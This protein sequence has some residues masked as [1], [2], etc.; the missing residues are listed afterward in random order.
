[1]RWVFVLL[2][3]IGVTASALAL[4]EHYRTD[5][6]PCSINE[7][8]DCGIVNHSPYAMLGKIPVAVIG[9]IGYFLLGVLALQ[10]A[11]KLMLA[12]ALGG[13]AF[14]LYLA[15]IESAVLGFWCI[16]CAI[17][18]G[19][20]S[21]ISLLSLVTVIVSAKSQSQNQEPA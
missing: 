2:A 17:S 5:A 20:I 7:K 11:Y 8:W 1:M 18:L 15:H 14:A 10:K 3:V 4:R 12:A 21:L 16:Y 9:M 13:L 19:V 6:S